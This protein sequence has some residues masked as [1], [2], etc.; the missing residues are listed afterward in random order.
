[1]N[2][3]K[4]PVKRRTRWTMLKL[5]LAIIMITGVCV[6]TGCQGKRA[7]R[8][9]E[10]QPVTAPARDT[11]IFR[12]VCFFPQNMWTSFDAEGD[13]NCEG[14]AFV[15]YLL[16]RQT[17]RGTLVPGTLHIDLYTVSKDASGRKTRALARQWSQPMDEVPRRSPTKF[18]NG[19]QPTVTWGEMDM[20]GKRVE[21][22]VRYE[23]PSGRVVQSQTHATKVPGRRE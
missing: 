12:V 5:P 11:D 7:R 2:E 6:P 19:Y 8:T 4:E 21:I 1:M 3:A 22:V 9:Q 20:L 17:E 10:H 18:G 23:S 13:L 16:S 15:M 14:F